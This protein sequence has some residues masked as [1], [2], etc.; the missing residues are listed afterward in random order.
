MPRAPF[1]V[2]VFPYRW[3]A[4]GAPEYALFLRADLGV[5]QAIAGGGEDAESPGQAAAREAE[6]EAGIAC[7]TNLRR[8]E[9]VSAV[10]VEHF[11]DRAH[12]DPALRE[13]PQY[14]FA[15]AVESEPLVISREHR[16]AAWFGIREALAAL[17]WESNRTALRELDAALTGGAAQE[18]PGTAVRRL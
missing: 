12:W 3:A 14:S 15:V 16:Q 1:Q 5:W 17:E 13:I 8:L 18:S 4:T 10:G 2:L 9:S 11:R 7:G 6:E